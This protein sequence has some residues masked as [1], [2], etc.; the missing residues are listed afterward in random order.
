MSRHSKTL[1]SACLSL[2]LIL[3]LRPGQALAVT[4]EDIESARARRDEIRAVRQEK[5]SLVDSLVRERAG[6]VEQKAAMDERNTA[7]LGQ[8]AATEDEIRLY[9]ELIEA[10]AIE[11]AA[12]RKREDEQLALYRRRVRTLEE[13]GRLSLLGVLLCSSDMREFLSFLD[14]VGEILRRDRELEDAYI[15]AR[16]DTERLQAEYESARAERRLCRDELRREQEELQGE[17]EEASALILSLQADIAAR[18]AEA[19][20]VLSAE[21]AADAELQRLMAELERQRREEEQRR[22]EQQRREEE[23]RRQ[24]EARREAERQAEESRRQEEEA[25]R[26]EAQVQQTPASITATGSFVWPVPGHTYVTSRFGLRVH[27]ITGV[28][29]THTGVDISADTG[30]PVVAADSASVTKATAYSGYGNCVILD[31]GNGYVTLYGHLSFFAVSEG[32]SVS[33]GQT[34]GYVGSTGLSTGPHCHFEVWSGGSRIDP[35][36]F[37]SGLSFSPSAGE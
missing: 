16:R 5:Q 7:T 31:H 33:Q 1:I 21:Y 24:E 32:E 9:D 28:K 11:V 10:K 19:D 37:F 22:L 6:V 4:Q 8:I 20:A 34:I 2:V 35:E 36:Q 3:S 26:Q 30:T 12:A 13:E 25:R 29:K 15:A 18:Q 14:D 27:P 23:A 17:I